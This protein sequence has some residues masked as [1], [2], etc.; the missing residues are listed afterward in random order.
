M[1][2]RLD[3]DDQITSWKPAHKKIQAKEPRY[4]KK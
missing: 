3:L 1:K 4:N 2:N